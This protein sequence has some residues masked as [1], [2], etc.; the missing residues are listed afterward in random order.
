MSTAAARHCGLP[1][2]PQP[3][4]D[5]LLGSWLL[6]AQLYG[7]GLTTLLSRL[8][9]RPVGDAHFPHWFAI[10][11]STVSLDALSAAA[12]LSRVDLAAMAPP[13]CRPRLAR[14]TR[15]LRDVPGGRRRGCSADYLESELDEP[16]GH[17]VQHPRHLADAGCHTHAGG[18]PSRRGFRRCSSADCGGTSLARLRASMCGRRPVVAGSLLCGHG[19]TLAMGEDPAERLDSDLGRGDLCGDL[20]IEFR[21][22]LRAIGQSS[23]TGSQGLR[24]RAHDWSTGGY[25]AANPATTTP[26]GPGQSRA[27]LAMGARGAD[28]PFRM[29][30]CI[31][32]AV[33]IDARLAR[34]GA[35]LGVP[36]CGRGWSGDRKSC[37]GNSASHPATSRPTRPYFCRSSESTSRLG[38]DAVTTLFADY[39]F[40]LAVYSFK[41][42][43]ISFFDR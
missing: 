41:F 30:S 25:V 9:A 13:S 23:S 31:G 18:R 7:L 33:G 29:V 37:K 24:V 4:P 19:R 38:F 39:S 36:Q 43:V 11:G 27:R 14:R 16:A 1:F 28:V 8:G 2:V 10:D 12:R 42:A 15:G 35:R 3:A 26:M 17:R 32:R 40:R 21:Q 22:R 20:G 34:R 5:E 6:H